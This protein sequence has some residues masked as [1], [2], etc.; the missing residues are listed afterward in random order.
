MDRC[1]ALLF[2]RYTK[3]KELDDGTEIKIT[4]S[5]DN[6]PPKSENLS[7]IA[8]TVESFSKSLVHEMLFSKNPGNK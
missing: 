1:N 8:K 2:G 4:V 7:V 6:C 3:E 5:V